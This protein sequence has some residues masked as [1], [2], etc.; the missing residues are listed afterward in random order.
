M[1]LTT[2][3][4]CEDRPSFLCNKTTNLNP[5]PQLLYKNLVKYLHI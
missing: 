3:L 4:V 2:R 1:K 5:N